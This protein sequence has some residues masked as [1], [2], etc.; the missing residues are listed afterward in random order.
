[1]QILSDILLKES[2]GAVI[3]AIQ[4]KYFEKLI[5]GKKNF[6]TISGIHLHS[7]NCTFLKCVN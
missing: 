6:Q 1:M 2:Y 4:F 7:P 5:T 3:A